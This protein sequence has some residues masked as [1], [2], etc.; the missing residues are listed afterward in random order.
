MNLFLVDGRVARDVDALV[1]GR[2]PAAVGV[3]APDRGEARD[4]LAVGRAR[5]SGRDGAAAVGGDGDEVGRPRER[6]GGLVEEALP[7]GDHLRAADA[8]RRAAEDGVLGDV[9]GERGEVAVGHCLR[10]RGLGSLDLVGD[11]LEL[12]GGQ[13]G[14]GGRQARGGGERDDRG[15]DEARAR[16]HVGVLRSGR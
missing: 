14:V 1:G 11:R 15:E 3:L 8:E 16:R 9:A 5:E 6:R 12:G 2:A 7:A 13:G 10:E 4:D